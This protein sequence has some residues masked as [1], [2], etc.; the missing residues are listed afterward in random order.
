MPL[1]TEDQFSSAANIKA[2]TKSFSTILVEARY[3]TSSNKTTS[4]FLSHS[5]TDQ[6]LVAKAVTFFRGLGINIYVDWM[7]QTMPEKPNGVTALK[8]KQK[9][10]T[11]NKFILLATNNAIISK[12]CNWELGIGDVYKLNSDKLAILP[13][14]DNRGNWLGNEYLQLYPRIEPVK[15]S[16]FEYYDNIFKVVYPNDSTKWLDDWLKS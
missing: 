14:A 9:I 8:I 7:D 3:D 1:F 5:H 16:N 15:K 12:W 2:G 10:Q 13:L 11:N 4:I 6:L